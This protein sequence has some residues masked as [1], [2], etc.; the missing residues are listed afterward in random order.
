MHILESEFES[1]ISREAEIIVEVEHA[2]STLGRKRKR[3]VK[4]WLRNVRRKKDEFLV[5][6]VLGRAL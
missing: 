3:E 4:N 6:E 2:E 1:L 5:W